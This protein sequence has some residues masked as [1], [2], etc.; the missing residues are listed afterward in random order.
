MPWYAW[1]RENAVV[2]S[3]TEDPFVRFQ[4]VGLLLPNDLGLF[5]TMGNA[6]EWCQDGIE[7]DLGPGIDLLEARPILANQRR[8]LKGGAVTNTASAFT[9]EAKGAEL[10]AIV[11]NTFGFRVARTYPHATTTAQTARTGGSSVKVP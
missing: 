6:Q 10:P 3:T 1:S 7:R 2:R 4:P 11:A 5:D 8:R 9:T